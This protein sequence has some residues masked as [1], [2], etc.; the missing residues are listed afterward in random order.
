MRAE[1]GQQ[2]LFLDTEIMGGHSRVEIRVTFCGRWHSGHQY[3][4]PQ[5]SFL[6]SLDQRLH[7]SHRAILRTTD[8]KL[9]HMR[10]SNICQK[11]DIRTS[12]ILHEVLICV[13]VLFLFSLLM[14]FRCRHYG[15]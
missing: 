14:I 9:D 5:C 2:E 3:W 11:Q 15:M 1:Q 13:G 4:L 12:V 6:L 10:G 7:G 8:E